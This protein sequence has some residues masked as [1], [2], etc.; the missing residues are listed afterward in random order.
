MA[1]TPTFRGSSLFSSS[2]DRLPLTTKCSRS[3][4]H[5]QVPQ[6]EDVIMC[7]Q[8]RSISY[9]FKTPRVSDLKMEILGALARVQ[10]LRHFLEQ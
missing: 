5:E 8:V 9:S 1:N 3:N 10:I 6:T 2:G 4:V 7:C